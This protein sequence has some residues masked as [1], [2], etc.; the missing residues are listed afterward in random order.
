VCSTSA[1]MLTTAEEQ[2]LQP[3]SHVVSCMCSRPTCKAT[4]DLHF[5]FLLRKALK[6]GVG[7][8]LR[9][10]RVHAGTPLLLLLL[11]PHGG[12]RCCSCTL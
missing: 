11:L 8:H 5:R 4:V 12:A 6:A 2:Q 9:E 10:T 3:T 7:V 1:D